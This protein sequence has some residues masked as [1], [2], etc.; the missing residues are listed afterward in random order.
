MPQKLQQITK[1][2]LSV[3]LIIIVAIAIGFFDVPQVYDRAIDF[4]NAKMQTT[5][6]HFVNIPFRLG[7]DL[8]GGTQLIYEADTSKIA[9]GEKG[10]AVEGVRDVIERRVNAFGVAEPVVQVNKA[11]GKWRVLVELAGVK[12]VNQ[13]IKM[14]GETPLLEFKEE[15]TEP[16]RELTPEERKAMNEFN[17]VAKDK[18]NKALKEALTGKDFSEVVKAYS[19]SETGVD[20]GGDFGWIKQTGEFAKLFEGASKTEIGK[21]VPKVIDADN[22]L[23]AAKVN[24][25][26]ESGQ[27]IKASHI[28]IC[29][30]GAESCTKE[31]T[32]E[33]AEK[34]VKDLKLKITSVNFAKMAKENST[35]SVAENGGELGWFQKG[36]MVKEFEDAAFALAKGNISEPVLTK[37]GY[38]LIYKTDERSMQEL[39]VS[40]VFVKT[41]KESDIL[42]PKDQWKSTQ[43][44]GKQLKNSR[45]NFNQSTNAPE[46]ALQFNDEGKKL[47]ADITSRN[48]GK[49]VAIFL[50]GQ[51]ISIP[52]VNEAITG[53]E[54]VITGNFDLAEA[55]QLTLRLNAGALPVPIKLLSQQTVGAS[56]G[57]E[58]LQKSLFAGLIGFVLVIIFMILYYRLP[59]FLAVVALIVYA[60]TVLFVF[61]AIPVTL[62]LAGIAGFI[63]SVGMAVDANVL[64]FERMREELRL[65][66]PLGTSIDVGFKRAWP[67][68]RDGNATTL[69]TCFI[70]AW[71]G[72][73]SI[74]GF[75]ITLGIGVI[76]SML[77]AIFVTRSFM[78]LFASDDQKRNLWW[79]GLK[80]N[81]DI[82]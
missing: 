49:P 62:T 40:A 32:K 16:A 55:K 59:G 64:I 80:K 24:D 81:K 53:G 6:P 79:F 67:S 72:T 66:K 14:I 3:V 61:K 41:K 47:F 70:L 15:N 34:I 29:Y 39:K 35:D 11:Q 45:V 33:E 7:L 37:F 75:G 36:Q 54:A 69:I 60:I 23:Y 57:A 42:P 78:Q 56:L 10:D 71:F 38:H 43:L 74:K 12:D 52:R 73:S 18:I 58:S 22:G 46:V 28:L 30:K 4:A 20:T 76:L 2:R 48:V 5:F 9:F 27:E 1:V 31:T 26:R 17:K 13:A 77:S 8:Q 65:G 21:V 44:T 68:I 19:E 63:L 82:Q 51:P 25:K 50:D